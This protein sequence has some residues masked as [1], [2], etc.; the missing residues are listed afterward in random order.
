M[1]QI[2][3]FLKQKLAESEYFEIIGEKTYIKYDEICVDIKKET[4]FLNPKYKIEFSFK[5]KGDKLCTMTCDTEELT[6]TLTINADIVG[7]LVVED[8]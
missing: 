6:D 4:D 3:K 1:N 7:R 2:T 8:E 5:Y